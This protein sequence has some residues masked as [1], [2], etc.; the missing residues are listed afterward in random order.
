LFVSGDRTGA[1]RTAPSWIGLACNNEE[2]TLRL[3]SAIVVE[4]VTVRGEGAVL[5]FPTGPP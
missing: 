3:L 1:R 2:M 5:W 4:N